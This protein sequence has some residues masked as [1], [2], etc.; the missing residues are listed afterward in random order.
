[1]TTLYGVT[2]VGAH[3]RLR[4]YLMADAS[5]LADAMSNSNI[6]RW[7]TARIPYP[8]TLADAEAFIC[9]TMNQSPTN[10]FMVEVEGELAGG[11]GLTPH[12]GEKLGVAEFGYWIAPQFWNR[13]IA[14]DAAHTLAEHALTVR[15]LRR[16]EAHVF[17]PNLASMRVLEK[18][19]F[20]REAIMRQRVVDRAGAVMGS[21]LYARCATGNQA[22]CTKEVATIT[23]DERT[24]G[25][26]TPE[27]CKQNSKGDCNSQE[28]VRTEHLR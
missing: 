9:Y 5:A 19:G 20:I 25:D 28:H 1:M 2:L 12:T 14:T 3:C 21:V 17:E 6:S 26:N 18:V 13:G 11:I 16:L 22:G 10:D 7:M 8:Y 27:H 23:T 4:P 24:E 15:K